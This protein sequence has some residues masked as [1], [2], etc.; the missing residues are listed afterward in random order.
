MAY[1][2]VILQ[3]GIFAF[4]VVGHRLEDET[5]SSQLTQRI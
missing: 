1:H 4:I 2:E 5:G 3:K